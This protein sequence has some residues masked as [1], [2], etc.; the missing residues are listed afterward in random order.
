M[1]H[2]L[3]ERGVRRPALVRGMAEQEDSAIRERA[4]RTALA[5]RRIPVDEALVLDG[6]F[7]QDLSYQVLRDLLT[8]RQDLDAV[9]ALNDE[10]AM[11]ALG[12][13]TEAGLRVPEDVVVTGFDNTK[14]AS[15]AWPGLTT[16]DQDLDRQGAVAAETLLAL[17]DGE[18]SERRERTVPSRLV[19]RGSTAPRGSRLPDRSWSPTDLQGMPDA[20]IVDGVWTI[21][22]DRAVKETVNAVE[23][24]ESARVLLAAQDAVL[25]MNR[26]LAYCSTIGDIV[27][28]LTERV[29]K[30]GVRR[31][32]LGVVDPPGEG[33]TAGSV[34][35]SARVLLAFRDGRAEEPSGDAFPRHELLPE[36]FRSELSDG[37]LALQPLSIAGRERG[38]L[39]F[40]PTWGPATLT[41]VL[42]IDLSRA[43]DTVFSTQELHDHAANLE[44]LVARRTRELEH[45]NEELRRSLMRDGLTQIANR[46]A[47]QEHLE[48]H[49][50]SA[51]P[52]RTE[53]A[54]LM[55]DVDL[56]KPFNDRYGHL[57]GDEELQEVAACLERAV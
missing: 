5:R 31:C 54:L 36:R 44:R 14:S 10:S 48:R 50:E 13:L 51:V 27:A 2:L 18:N 56:F 7:R 19:V 25:G 24:A 9:V 34:D 42:R 1:A 37:V 45:A 46:L 30:L 41:E 29:D 55:V 11:G 6:H 20:R 38:Y 28:V 32:F 12:A 26:A 21:S 22:V 17:V 15:L 23:M 3:D 57:R 52:G 40:E 43:L 39:L 47:F 4:F 33:G 53:L 35:Q 49:L 16:V 8:R